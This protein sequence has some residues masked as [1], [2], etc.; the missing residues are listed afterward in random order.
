MAKGPWGGWFNNNNELSINEGASAMQ[1]ANTIFGD[2]VD[3][4]G[5][6]YFGASNSSGVYTGANETMP[7]VAPSDTGVIFST[8]NAASITNGS[9][10]H[11]TSTSTSANTSGIDN[12]AAFNALAGTNTYDASYLTVNF[13]PT[14][15]V[16]TLQFVFSSEEYPEYS[17]SIFND[18]VGVWINDELVPIEVGNG[19]TSVT[20]I[21]Q[22][23]NI[24][25]FTSNANGAYNTEMDGFTVTMTV[26]IPVNSGV[27]NKITIGIA[28][29][30]DSSYDSNLM[31]AGGS[32]QTALVALGDEV[33]IGQGGSKTLD[34]LGNDIGS[35]TITVTHINGNAVVAGDT[36][37]LA[38]GQDI[39]L[40]ADGTFTIQ[41]D[42]DIEDI[43]FTYGISD[44]AG[45]SDTGMVSVSTV[46]CFVAGTRI[47]TPEGEVAV[48]DLCAGDIVMTRDDGPQILRWAGSRRVAAKGDHAPIRILAG[49]FGAHG[50]LM[51]SPQHRVLIAD[52]LAEV[53]FGEPEVLVAAK[54]LINDSTVRRI[55]GGH[56]TYC[57]LLFDSHQVV[58]SQGLATESFLPG[59]QVLNDLDQ[60]VVDE[61]CTIFPELD[62]KS[63]KGGPVAARQL[64]KSYEAKLWA[65][66][67]N[68]AQGSTHRGVAA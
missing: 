60:A 65:C 56:V 37:T 4:R 49:T 20:N 17:G 41:A 19:A 11:N 61:I 23:S 42:D 46:P 55:E 26:T 48:E 62:P 31:V 50:T 8:G 51:I 44:G 12:N 35:G 6:T 15:D 52:E 47:R 9:G 25:L 54:D 7:G 40:N 5:A 38:T 18:A 33:E 13:V 45:H 43:N 16:M 53:L 39:T 2:G 64:L 32:G 67:R 34:V 3:V 21:N 66:A 68:G 29:T 22:N 59:P 1:M 14:G 57:H 30:A 28:D 36:I 10:A 24:N 58:W 63:G 27:M